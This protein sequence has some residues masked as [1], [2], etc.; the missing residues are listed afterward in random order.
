VNSNPDIFFIFLAGTLFITIFVSALILFL[1]QYKRKQVKFYTEKLEIQHQYDTQLLQTKLEVQE[2]SFKQYSEEIH[3]NT[4]QLLSS[5]KHQ[6]F[7][8]KDEIN[9]EHIINRVTEATE[10]LGRAISDL[11]DISHI[12]NNSFI[13]KAGVIDAVEKELKYINSSK[14]LEA[15]LHLAG[16][17]YNLGNER[18][19]L[20]FR[21]IQEAIAN[22]LK[23]AKPAAINVYLDYSP[24]LFAVKIEDNG[25][26]FHTT[27]NKSDGIGL[28]NM[29]VRAGM[30]KGRLTITSLIER[31]TSVCLEIDNPKQ[32]VL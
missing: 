24:L 1:I 28:D 19:L 10:L 16:E 29:H 18:E 2:Q 7:H 23:H 8:I 21:I 31:G 13:A 20:V 26:G 27:E 5:V 22:A 4:G 32:T 11:R 3:D 15:R 12:L 17:E 14:R 6:L 30:L 25:V 9:D